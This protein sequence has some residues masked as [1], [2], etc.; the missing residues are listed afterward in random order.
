MF[1]LL[2]NCTHLKHQQS[3]A[4]NSP[5]QVSTVCELLY[6]LYVQASFRIEGG[7]RDKLPTFVG[8]SK[9]KRIQE[10][11]ILLLY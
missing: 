2:H 5:S 8:L 4:K 6:T 1:K 3:N 11:H 10:K 7:T 9:S